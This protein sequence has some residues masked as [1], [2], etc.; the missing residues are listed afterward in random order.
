[1]SKPKIVRREQDIADRGKSV[2][3][4]YECVYV[5]HRADTA[6]GPERQ[7]E[8]C[9]EDNE[10]YHRGVIIDVRPAEALK[11]EHH[12][13]TYDRAVYQRHQERA[14]EARH[15]SDERDR[16]KRRRYPGVLC[17]RDEVSDID[18]EQNIRRH[19][20]LCPERMPE[21]RHI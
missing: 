7:Q 18:S 9:C 10:Q 15:S 13:K 5:V 19:Y 1:M 12:E 2:V 4:G 11:R 20:I 6:V 17:D 3:A 14:E 8:Q 16:I 21:P